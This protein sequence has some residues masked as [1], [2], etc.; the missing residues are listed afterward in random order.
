MRSYGKFWLSFSQ[1]KNSKKMQ[2]N[3]LQSIYF[4]CHLV[5]ILEFMKTN[6]DQIFCR[7]DLQ[8]VV[9]KAAGQDTRLYLCL[10]RTL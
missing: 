8:N 2:G 7:T 4:L 1:M 5:S 3:E 10:K 6:E 9:E